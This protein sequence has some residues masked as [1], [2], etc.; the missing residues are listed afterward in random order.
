MQKSIYSKVDLTEL[1]NPKIKEFN[2]MICDLL[3][4]D[5]VQ[6]LKGFSQHMDTTRFQHSI[7]V[8]YYTFL[9]CRKFNLKTEE[10]T[11]AALLHDLFLYNWRENKEEGWHPSTHPKKALENSQRLVEVTPIMEDC[12]VKHM[13]PMTL[14]TPK[15]KEGWVVTSMDKYCAALECISQSSRKLKTSNAVMYLCSIIPFITINH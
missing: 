3:Q 5:E 10:A 13:W 11:R 15:Y 12:I 1:S 9:I 8:A 2:D 6:L 14:K 4:I 7:N